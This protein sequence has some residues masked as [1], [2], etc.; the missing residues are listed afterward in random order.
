M[1]YEVITLHVR[2]ESLVGPVAAAPAAASA[3][4]RPMP[5]TGAMPAVGA[6]ATGSA[7][8]S[9]NEPP[10]PTEAPP[11]A[12]DDIEDISEDDARAP[13]AQLSGAE[14]RNNFV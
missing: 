5:S 3:P 7:P 8:L 4:S 14:V 1:L 9:A 11:P 10:L 6:P 13:E 12:Y 2:V